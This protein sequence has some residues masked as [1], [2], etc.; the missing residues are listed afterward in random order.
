MGKE[1]V[2]PRS[3]GPAAVGGAKAT[4]P[5]FAVRV[6]RSGNKR[7]KRTFKV[8]TTKRGRFY[9]GSLKILMWRKTELSLF[10]T[11][12]SVFSFSPQFTLCKQTGFRP[13]SGRRGARSIVMRQR[14]E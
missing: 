11:L 4:T 9:G 1:R 3:E 14:E 12:L 8:T 6:F 13:R 10:L 2:V 7:A 5:D